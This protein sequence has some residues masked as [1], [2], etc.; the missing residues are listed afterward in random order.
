VLCCAVLCCAVLW[1]AAPFWPV[2]AFATKAE[3]DVEVL[4]I[5]ELYRGVYEMLALPVIKGKKTENEKFAG[6]D[7]TTTVEAFIPAVGRAIQGATSHC[8]G[9]NFAKVCVVAWVGAVLRCGVVCV[10]L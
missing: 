8:L 9:Q 7:Y 1:C 6:G 3:A 4:Q 2:A 5:L 10:V